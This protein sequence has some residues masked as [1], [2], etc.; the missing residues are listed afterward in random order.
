MTAGDSNTGEMRRGFADL[1][2]RLCGEFRVGVVVR[3]ATGIVPSS[4]VSLMYDELIGVAE[5][6]VLRSP[7]EVAGDMHPPQR[8]SAARPVGVRTGP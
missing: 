7:V 6:G 8:R 2:A 3:T 5:A 4:G 1:R